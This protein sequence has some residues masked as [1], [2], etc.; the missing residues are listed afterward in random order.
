MRKMQAQA[1]ART[2]DTL[3]GA[4]FTVFSLTMAVVAVAMLH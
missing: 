4:A 3:T 1:R 2:A